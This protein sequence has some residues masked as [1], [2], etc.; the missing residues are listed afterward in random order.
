MTVGIDIDDTITETSL[1]ANLYL[2]KNPKYIGIIDY[3][4]LEQ[5]EFV[6]FVKN[7]VSDIQKNAPLKTGVKECINYL[8]ENGHKV[9]LITARGSNGFDFLIPETK[10]YLERNNIIVDDI[11][12]RKKY[13]GKTCNKEKVDIFIDDKEKVLDEVKKWNIKTIRFCSKKENSKHYKANS[14]GHLLKMFEEG[15]DNYDIN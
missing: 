15:V 11:V 14:W 8:R 1:T 10:Q 9:I 12:F 6:N 7:N 5:E 13:K 3:H 2:Q 4:E